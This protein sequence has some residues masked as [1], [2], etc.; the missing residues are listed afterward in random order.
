MTTAASTTKEAAL[1]AVPPKP[2]PEP[3]DLYATPEH[4]KTMAK[5]CG[6]KTVWDDDHSSTVKHYY[7]LG[8]PQFDIAVG[9]GTPSGKILEI[10]GWQSWGKSTIALELAF[11]F[12]RYWQ[13]VGGQNF[14]VLWIETETAF[15]K[16]RA[17]YIAPGLPAYFGLEEHSILEDAYECIKRVL[18]HWKKNGIMGFVVWDTIAA[19][20]TRNEKKGD[21]FGGGMMEKARL[22]R[23]ML[24]ELDGALADVDATMVICNHVHSGPKP[25]VESSGGGGIRFHADVRLHLKEPEKLKELQP[26]GEEKEVG[27]LVSGRPV[28]NKISGI[29][30][31]FRLCVMNE[32]GIDKLRSCLEYMIEQKI[33]DTKAGWKSFSYP[34]RLWKP[35]DAPGAPEMVELKFQNLKRV[36]EEMAVTAPHIEDWMHY[37]IYRHNTLSAP[38]VKVRIIDKVWDYE[39]K[40]YG[41]RRTVLTDQEKHVAK[42]QHKRIMAEVAEE[43]RKEAA[44]LAKGAKK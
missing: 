8:V 7:P 13:K 23:A 20:V 11:S 19:V 41:Q 35:G 29:K 37:L 43:E 30:N 16:V 10:A 40:F 3:H 27:L 5:E 2:A 31:D 24:K 36:R 18:A 6:V 9:S 28:K 42:Q 32:S 33:I 14:A 26:N 22:I 1:K 39:L 4:I 15:D 21:T 12:C 25:G 44:I 34:K 17:E 38:L